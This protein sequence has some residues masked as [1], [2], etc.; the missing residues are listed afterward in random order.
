MTSMVC[1]FCPMPTWITN[2]GPSC[3][4]C[5]ASVK[6]VIVAEETVLTHL[7]K[8]ENLVA[9]FLQTIFKQVSDKRSSKILTTEALDNKPTV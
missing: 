9:D 2:S 1:A 4:L 7:V 5:H 3:L 6:L 8:I